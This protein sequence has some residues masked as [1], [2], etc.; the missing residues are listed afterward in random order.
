MLGTPVQ[1]YKLTIFLDSAKDIINIV[2]EETSRIEHRLYETGNC[3]DGHVFGVCMAIPLEMEHQSK[4]QERERR[5][6]SQRTN[7]QTLSHFLH[8]H[9]SVCSKTIHS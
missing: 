5:Q 6:T 1:G 2:R 9:I 4:L 8:E 3:A 7:L